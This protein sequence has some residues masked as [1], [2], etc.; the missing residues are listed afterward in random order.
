MIVMILIP[1]STCQVR[2]CNDP[3]MVINNGS[4][5]SDCDLNSK[6]PPAKQRVL[7]NELLHIHRCALAI[8]AV[9]S[10]NFLIF[11]SDDDLQI[12]G[13]SLLHCGWRG[14][15]LHCCRGQP[16]VLLNI[17]T[18]TD[19]VFFATIHRWFQRCI[20]LPNICTK[21]IDSVKA[22]DQTIVLNALVRFAF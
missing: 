17:N 3:M 21:L 18:L 6:R 14:S 5:S 11:C 2:T 15:N 4:V 20:F 8:N 10:K 16:R 13:N 1:T 19:P 7:L 9:P 22:I 12:P